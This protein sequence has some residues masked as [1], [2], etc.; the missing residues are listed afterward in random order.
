MSHRTVA[1]SDLTR[2]RAALAYGCHTP[3]YRA[4]LLSIRKGHGALQGACCNATSQEAAATAAE[5]GIP[6][7]Y[8]NAGS[9]GL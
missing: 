5:G 9:C 7:S 1:V 2:M 8:F 6:F 4:H 3:L